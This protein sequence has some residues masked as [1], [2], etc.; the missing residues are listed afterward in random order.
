MDGGHGTQGLGAVA[1][2]LTLQIPARQGQQPALPPRADF[3]VTSFGGLN[4]LLSLQSLKLVT[5]GDR[6]A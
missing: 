6:L 5:T 1:L 3:W 4:T 2:R